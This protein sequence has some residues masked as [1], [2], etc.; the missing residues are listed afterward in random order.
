MQEIYILTEIKGIPLSVVISSAN[1]THDIKLVTNV[2]N[3]TVVKRPSSSC[4][5]KSYNRKRNKHHHLCLDKAYNSKSV[6]QEII[7]REYV[8]HIIYKRKRG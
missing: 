7:K 3:N 5:P 4:P 6:K 1:N 8:P 2:I